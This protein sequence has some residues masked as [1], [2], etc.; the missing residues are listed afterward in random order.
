MS[1]RPVLRIHRSAVEIEW[2]VEKIARPALEIVCLDI[3]TRRRV[4]TATLPALE[5]QCRVAMSTLPGVAASCLVAITTSRGVKTPRRIAT[6]TSLGLA[7]PC[8]E[9]TMPCTGPETRLHL[10]E[11]RFGGLDD[12][13]TAPRTSRDGRGMQCDI[14]GI[15]I[16]WPGIGLR[17]A[18]SSLGCRH[19]AL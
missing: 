6:T 16:P 11:F 5:T 8:P 17:G 12:E 14:D 10:G 15:H 7:T 13:S 4:A 1:R 18:A 2:N 19:S 9:P 3:V